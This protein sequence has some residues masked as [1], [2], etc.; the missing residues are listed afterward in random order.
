MRRY[1]EKLLYLIQHKEKK[2]DNGR[3][4]IVRL[5]NADYVLYMYNYE[6]IFVVAM[7]II[8]S[9]FFRLDIG[10]WYGDKIRGRESNAI[11]L[12]TPKVARTG[13]RKRDNC[14]SVYREDPGRNTVMTVAV[15]LSQVSHTRPAVCK[16]RI[17]EQ[18]YLTFKQ[19]AI[20]RTRVP[21]RA[22]GS[23]DNDHYLHLTS[24]IH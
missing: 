3:A 4:Q 8:F 17:K 22:H 16:F 5:K 14:V 10:I 24:L 18:L 7:I 1:N 12:G 13:P 21:G 20:A 2:I 19:S 6:K 23:E 9:C 15:I 11:E